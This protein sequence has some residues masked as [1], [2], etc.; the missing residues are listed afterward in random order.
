MG[1]DG[2]PKM[3]RLIKIVY[4]IFH[5]P[6]TFFDKLW[7]DLLKQRFIQ[8]KLDPFL[9]IKSDILCLFYVYNVI[10]IGSKKQ[11]IES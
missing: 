11:A 7:P 8:S 5:P 4:G 6:K 10:L 1:S 3:P 2:I 9:F